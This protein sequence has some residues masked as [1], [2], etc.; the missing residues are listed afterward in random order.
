MRKALC[1]LFIV[2]AV[3]SG[4]ADCSKKEPQPRPSKP[5]ISAQEVVLCIDSAFKVREA[6][7][8]CAH[9][10]D[11][12]CYLRYV[13]NQQPWPAELPAINERL[14][15][16]R[17]FTTPLPGSTPATIPPEGAIFQR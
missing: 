1:V 8:K 9:P 16:G 4:A 2:L 15:D 6:D 5:V 17:G 14:E 11:N 10:V 12:C 13:R 7:E 3:G